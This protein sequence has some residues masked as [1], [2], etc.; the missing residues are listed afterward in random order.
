MAAPAAGKVQSPPKKAAAAPTRKLMPAG[1]RDVAL[2]EGVRTPFLKSGTEC[3][4]P[5]PIAGAVWHFGEG[6]RLSGWPW[7]RQLPIM[8]PQISASAERE[9]RGGAGI[10]YIN[11][12]YLSHHANACSFGGFLAHDL[13]REALKGL[14]KRTAMDTSAVDYICMGTVIQESKTSN[15]AREVRLPALPRSQNRV[16]ST[17]FPGMEAGS[18]SPKT[19]ENST[20]HTLACSHPPPPSP[21][22]N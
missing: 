12:I 3:V 4:P 19:L 18:S 15:V 14:I 10:V 21:H 7:P 11:H 2:I 17:L 9:S 8:T 6:K 22:T 20:V 5:C 1:P 16:P 13:A